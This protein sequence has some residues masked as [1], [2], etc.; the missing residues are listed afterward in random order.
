MRPY[1]AIEIDGVL[2]PYD[3]PLPAGHSLHDVTSAAWQEWAAMVYPRPRGLRLALNAEVG[4]ALADLP[5]DLV[6]VSSYTPGELEP[7]LPALGWETVPPLVPMRHTAASAL[8]GRSSSWKRRT[9]VSSVPVATLHR[10]AYWGGAIFVST[11][12]DY[13]TVLIG[14]GGFAS[15]QPFHLVVP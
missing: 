6:L 1:I 2:A 10:S 3:G 4:R 5:A 11:E 9:S 14:D 8:S 12:T 15:D 13:I 7:L